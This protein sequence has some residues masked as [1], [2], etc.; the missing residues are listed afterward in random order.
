MAY[1]RDLSGRRLDDFTVAPAAPYTVAPGAKAVFMG[2][3]ITN[4]SNA[5]AGRRWIDQLLR[6]IGTANLSATSVE[7]GNAGERLDTIL[8][9]YDADVRDAGAGIVFL[10]AGTNDAAQGRTLAQFAA[11][12][13]SFATETRKDGIPL[14]VGTVP[15]VA[16]SQSADM[17]LRIQQYNTWLT[18]WAPRAGV[19]LAEVYKALVSSGTDTMLGGFD[20]DGIHPNALGHQEIAEAFAAAYTAAFGS[21]AQHLVQAVHTF[22]LVGNPLFVSD[23][24]NG[25]FNPGGTLTPTVSVEADSTGTL[26]A[27]QWGKL[28]LDGTSAGGVGRRAYNITGLTPGDTLLVTARTHTTDVGGGFL[29]AMQGEGYTADVSLRVTYGNLT[30]VANLNGPAAVLNAGPVAQLVTVPPATTNLYLLAQATVP[31][32]QHVEYRIGEAG[33]FNVTNLPDLAALT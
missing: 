12:M 5:G 27:G 31:T 26:L 17:R 24:S 16:T 10:L 20:S 2:D 33:V 25:W 19:P 6:I 32:G 21:P 18:S 15:P 7:A 22:N 28:V 14:I 4:G 29:P 23:F 8:A 11:D 3:S 1:M 13:E 9:R 30:T